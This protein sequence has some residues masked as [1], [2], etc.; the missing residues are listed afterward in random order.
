M[1]RREQAARWFTRLL[2]LPSGHPD[3]QAFAAWLAADPRNAAEYE[4][5]SQLWGGFSH[6]VNTQALAGA[7][8]QVSRRRLLRKGMLGALLLAGLGGWLSVRGWRQHE[9]QLFT[10]IGQTR[11]FVLDD[12]SQ[13]LLEGNS[14]VH[15]LYSAESRHLYLLQGRAIFE[16]RADAARPF[17]V[18]AG[19]VGVRVLGTR[20][21]VERLAGTVRVSVDH[22]RVAFASARQSL[23]LGAGQVAEFDPQGQLRQVARP[24]SN[25]FSFA[26]GTLSFDQAS[27][28][29]LATVLS[30][31]RQRPLQVVSSNGQTLTAV[32]QVG[33]VEAFI[34][35]L[36]RLLAVRLEERGGVSEI[37]GGG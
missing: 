10:G 29:E 22:G 3:R 9:Q 11:R 26:E 27:L 5:F 17:L 16:V 33:D 13:L 34:A 20:F 35:S 6:T 31:Y 12:G 37:H 23:Q 28:D 25:A 30:R 8:E 15:V 21:A 4:A 36:P 14:R 2:D 19:Q 1:S 32:I 18:E 7:M 24:A